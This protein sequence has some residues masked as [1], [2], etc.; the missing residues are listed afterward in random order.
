[1]NIIR[2]GDRMKMGTVIEKL[3]ENERRMFYKLINYAMSNDILREIGSKLELTEMGAKNEEV[4]KKNMRELLEE[5][6]TR[7][8]INEV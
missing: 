2:A 8:I 1:M 4:W 5:Y 6:K 7:L 3:E